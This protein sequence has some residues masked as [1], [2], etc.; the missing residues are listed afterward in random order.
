MEISTTEAKVEQAA[1]EYA[2]KQN[3]NF[4]QY[5]SLLHGMQEFSKIDFTAGATFATTDPAIVEQ[6][7]KNFVDWMEKEYGTIQNPHW[8]LTKY[9][10]HLQT[11]KDKEDV[12]NKTV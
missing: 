1:K 8:V 7:I 4:R 3:T 12:N 2:Y 11:N 6:L 9:I 10:Q 5:G